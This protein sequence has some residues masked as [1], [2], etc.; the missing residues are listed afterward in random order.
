MD[1]YED[2][3]FRGVGIEIELPTAEDFHKVKETLTRIGVASKKD[4][5]LYQSCHILH[6]QGRYA[7]VHFKEMFILDGKPTTLTDEDLKRRNRI[8][9]LLEDWKLVRVLDRDA[10]V[11]DELA[12]MAH[13]KIISFSD[14]RNWTLEEKYQVGKRKTA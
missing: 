13:I 1:E 11:D 5:K 3:I 9:K 2:D 14:K 8:S 4:K 6:K 7:I 10:I 12:P